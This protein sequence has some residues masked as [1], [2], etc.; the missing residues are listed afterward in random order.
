[1]ERKILDFSISLLVVWILSPPLQAQEHGS[2]VVVRDN[3]ASIYMTDPAKA[4]AWEKEKKRREKQKDKIVYPLYNGVSLGVDLWGPGSKLF[5]N[6]ALTVEVSADVNLKNCFLPTLELGYSSI[7]SW[8]DNGSRFKT[9]A[10]YLRVGLDYN[11]FSQNAYQHKLLVGVRYGITRFNYDVSSFDLED[12]LYGGS[13]NPNLSDDVWGGYVP[14]NYS[15]MKASVQWVELC[16]GLRAHIAGPLYMGWSIRF[17]FDLSTSADEHA[18]PW[19]IPGYG[20][21]CEGTKMGITYTI[22]Y[23]L[24]F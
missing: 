7:D 3:S 10:P 9:A 13:I 8:S 2:S 11:A 15:D 22:I 21:R 20:R 18:A 6:D 23:K 24:P 14:Y 16:L 19:Y 1:M 12:P 5:G 17:K 4:Q